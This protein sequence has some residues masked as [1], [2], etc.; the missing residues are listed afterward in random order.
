MVASD[1]GDIGEIVINDWN[2][3]KVYLIWKSYCK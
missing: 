2:G 1:I 3:V